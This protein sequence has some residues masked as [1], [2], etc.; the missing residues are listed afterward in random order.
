[1]DDAH[2][3]VDVF[4]EH[5]EAGIARAHHAI[6]R[7][8]HG[9]GVLD[10]DHIDARRHNL[11]RVHVAKIQNLVNHALFVVEQL[12]AVRNEI[13]DFLFRRGR[14]ALLRAQKTEQ[15]LQ[16]L[17]ATVAVFDFAAHGLHR[18]PFRPFP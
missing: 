8:P 14:L 9:F 7:L 4:M 5:R 16:T 6:N 12:I 1:M 13:L 17:L 2:D 10:Q 15:A 3:A 18:F 11:A